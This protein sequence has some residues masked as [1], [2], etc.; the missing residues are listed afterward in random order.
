M[1][2]LFKKI[3]PSQKGRIS[4]VRKDVLAKLLYDA[5]LHRS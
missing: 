2:L 4:N 5:D 3:R 1:N